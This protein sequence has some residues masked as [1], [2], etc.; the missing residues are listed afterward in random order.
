MHWR[1]VALVLAIGSIAATSGAAQ[2]FIVAQSQNEERVVG[3]LRLPEIYGDY[4]CQ[5]FEPAKVNIYSEPSSQRAPIGAIERVN[6]IKPPEH[7][8]CDTPVVVVRRSGAGANPEAFP[9]D[10]S[11]EDFTTAVVYERSGLWF[12]IALTHGSGWIRRENDEGFLAYPEILMSESFLTYLRPGWDGSLWTEPG[13]GT[14]VP[15]PDAWRT[16]RSRE[17]PVRITSTRKVGNDMW[18]QIR[19]E[20]ETCGQSL[21]KLPPLQGWIP[22]HRASRVTSVWFYSRG[23]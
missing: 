17:I 3:L 21:G 1:R 22:A 9:S 6:P 7:P 8:D 23:C 20:T 13:R 11:G 4:P 19:F 15:A 12:R 16:H 5:A 10:E 14:A 2:D 18:I